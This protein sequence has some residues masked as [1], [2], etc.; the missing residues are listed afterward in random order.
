MRIINFINKILYPTRYSSDA[1]IKHMKKIGVKIGEG[2]YIFE[3]K[4]VNIDLYRP[5]LLK[6]GNNVVL[7]ANSTILT[8]DYS[9]CVLNEK[10]G[11]NIGDAKPVKIGDNVFVGID[12]MILMGTEIGNNVIIGAKSVVFGKIPDNC[13]VAG[14]PAKIIC[15]LDEFYKKRVKNEIICAKKNVILAKGRIGRVPTVNEMGDAFAWLYLPRTN[16]SIQKYPH[17]FNLPGQ[18]NEK[19][20]ENFLKSIPLYDSYEIFINEIEDNY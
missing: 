13:V 15:S 10:Y 12:A 2:C 6:I 9:H 11:R 1:Y 3:P 8:H 4:S 20:K 16:E 14:N 17:F 7:C 19:V 18:N 5:Y